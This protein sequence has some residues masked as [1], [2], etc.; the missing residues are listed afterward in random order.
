MICVSI[1]MIRNTL[2]SILLIF[3]FASSAFS[4][5]GRVGMLE[6]TLGGRV[7]VGSGISFQ[8]FPSDEN[9]I[10]LIASARWN[11]ISTTALYQYHMRM[12]APGLKWYLGAGAHA[13]ALNVGINRPDIKNDLGGNVFVPGLDAVVGIE[14]FFRS[15]PFM[16]SFDYKPEYN[17]GIVNALDRNIAAFS[18]RYRF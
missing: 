9:A 10:E 4:Q 15:A 16:V 14:Y 18:F 17:F 8:Y 7:G 1:A 11:A 3:F 6:Y 2:F 12:P 5:R 13:T